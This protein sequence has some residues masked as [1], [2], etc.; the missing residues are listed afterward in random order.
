MGE[1]NLQL[2]EFVKKGQTKS[3]AL[4]SFKLSIQFNYQILIRSLSGL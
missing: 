1:T 2:I 3:P 4:F